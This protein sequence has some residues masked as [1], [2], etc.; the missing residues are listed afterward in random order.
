MSKFKE[1]WKKA[2]KPFQLTENGK[3]VEEFET[4]EEAEDA[5]K[6]LMRMDNKVSDKIVPNYK[7]VRKEY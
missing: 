1:F 6:F 5:M 2:N 3:V 4:K 7:I